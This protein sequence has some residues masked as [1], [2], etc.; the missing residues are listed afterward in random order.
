[1]KRNNEY[2]KLDG[3]IIPIEEAIKL[4]FIYEKDIKEKR[5]MDDYNAKDCEQCNPD[6]VCCY[7]QNIAWY[8]LKE[9][10][11]LKEQEC[12]E[13][14][15]QLESTKGLVKV[16]NRQLA[17]A[18]EKNEELEKLYKANKNCFEKT[19]KLFDESE[20]ERI[21]LKQTLAEIKEV[22]QLYNN[23]TIGTYKGNGVFEFEAFNKNVL[24]GKVIYYYDTNPARK[25]L[26]KI[27]EC[28]GDNE[29]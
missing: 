6:S 19:E 9:Q 28:E 25:A 18:L 17:E 27:N 14:K 12:E 22:L 29:V 8:K 20:Q 11:K 23:T 10:L 5:I 3:I 21:K 15:E 4:G 16:G 2:I 26:R 13:L 1:M 24:G 7:C